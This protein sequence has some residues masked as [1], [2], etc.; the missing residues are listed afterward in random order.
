MSQANPPTKDLYEAHASNN[1]GT[2]D[3]RR[4]ERLIASLMRAAVA[5]GNRDHISAIAPVTK[6]AATLVPPEVS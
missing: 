2:T 5:C 6:G 1:G 4:A 3:R